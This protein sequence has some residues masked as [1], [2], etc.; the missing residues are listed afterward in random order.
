MEEDLKFAFTPSVIAVKIL[1]VDDNEINRMLAEKL[2]TKF[3]FNVVTVDSGLKAIELLKSKD[4]DV[5][6][7]DVHMPGM[8]GYETA[9]TLRAMDD[10]Y[11]KEIPIIALTAS[12]MMDEL[13][14]VHDFGMT[15]YQIKP[16][17]PEE[18]FQKIIKYLKK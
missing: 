16:F 1:V 14:T 4:F 9:Q 10:I 8:S 12:I 15:D 3:D 7:L 2:L 13:N 5:V 6:L 17:K 18:L 11:F